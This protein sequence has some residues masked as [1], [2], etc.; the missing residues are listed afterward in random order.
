MGIEHPILQ[1]TGTSTLEVSELEN[2]CPNGCILASQAF[3]KILGE[4]S[5]IHE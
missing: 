1:V 2:I 5:G 4:K 3:H